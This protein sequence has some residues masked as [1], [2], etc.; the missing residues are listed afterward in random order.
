MLPEI[1]DVD[2]KINDEITDLEDVDLICSL[3][4]LERKLVKFP[5]TSDYCR[6][7]LRDLVENFSRREISDLLHIVSGEL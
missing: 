6:M 4:H 2:D 5:I 1:L 3:I 7:T